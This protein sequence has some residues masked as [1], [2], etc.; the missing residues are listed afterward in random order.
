MTAKPYGLKLVYLALTLLALLGLAQA[1]EEPSQQEP[2]SGPHIAELTIDGAIGVAT[3]D[4]LVRALEQAHEEGAHAVLIRMDTPGGLDA[5]TRDIIK[6]ILASPIP[7][8]TYVHPAGARAASAGTYILYG[9]QVA[10]MTPATNLGAATPVQ[11]GGLPTSPGGEQDQKPEE[12]PADSESKSDQEGEEGEAAEEEADSEEVP[13]GDAMKRKTIND[14]VAFIRGLAERHG[15]NADWA[16]KAVREA[17]SL[18]ATKALEKNVIDLVAENRED[19]LAQLDGLEL[20]LESGAYTLSTADLPIKNYDPDWRSEFLGVITNPQIA[21]ILLLI[22]VYGLILEGYN[23]GAMVPG[24][25][26][27]ICLLLGLYAVQVLPVNY[28]GLALLLL[29]SILILAEAFVPSFGVI[30][31]IM[32]SIMLVDT[33]VPGME[34]SYDIL[35]ALAVLSILVL[36]LV[37]TMVGRSLRMPRSDISQSMVGRELTVELVN[38]RGCKLLVDGEYWSGWSDEALQE[39]DRVEVVAQEGLKLKVRKKREAEANGEGRV[40]S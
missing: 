15:R 24:I 18:T 6:A 39:G 29:G 9:S 5:A 34:V 1:Q 38:D 3:K 12:E 32:G 31:I 36:I 26:G 37:V 30:A 25:V 4:Y 21:S 14:S 2:V 13:Q 27:I 40:V 10:A 7:V 23:P 28:A 8:I 17:V 19:L 11:M 16:E 33:D 20:E 22:G 35:A